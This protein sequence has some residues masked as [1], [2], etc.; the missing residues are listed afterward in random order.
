MAY[1]SLVLTHRMMSDYEVSLV[2]DNM[3]EFYVRFYGPTESA[4]L[5]RLSCLITCGATLIIIRD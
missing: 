3:Q 4:S 1:L 5:R 2:N